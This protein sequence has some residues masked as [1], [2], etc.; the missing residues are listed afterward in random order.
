MQRKL[1][2]DYSLTSVFAETDNEAVGF[3]TKFGF[4]ITEFAENYGGETVIQYRCELITE[5]LK[6]CSR[7][8]G[9]EKNYS[10]RLPRK[11]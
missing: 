11:R 5:N 6:I 9:Y 4:A 7:K 8:N 3:Y 2:E 10:N 1:V